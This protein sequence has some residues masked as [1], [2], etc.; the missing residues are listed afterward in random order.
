MTAKLLG[1]RSPPSGDAPVFYDFN[2]T[3]NICLS[4]VLSIAAKLLTASLYVSFFTY[5]FQI[6]ADV[7]C[8]Y[9]VQ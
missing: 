6:L 7:S 8:L 9:I 5:F 1:G 2:E 4:Y 3:L